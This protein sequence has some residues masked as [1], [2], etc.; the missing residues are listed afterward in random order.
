MW[1]DLT[2]PWRACLEEMWAAYCAGS[3]PV[4][5][6]V[7]DARGR[8]VA[9]GRNRSYER[10]GESHRRQIR[11]LAHA[12]IEALDTLDYTH[13]D[14]HTCVLYTSTEPCP[15][16]L[17][18]LYMSGVR[19]FRYAA[20]DPYAGSANLLGTTPYL[21]QKPIRV[22]PPQSPELETVITAVAVEFALR[23]PEPEGEAPARPAWRKVLPVWGE[24]IPGGVRLG[25]AVF[26]TGWLERMRETWAPAAQ[27]IDGLSERARTG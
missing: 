23:H 6:V 27:V 14:P 10:G 20:R 5:A 9:R 2:E 17:G 18:A 15:L 25:E 11:P 8:I 4:G 22:L 26:A 21:R 16:C 13:S 19:E 1:K 7:A 3:I 24:V 12:E